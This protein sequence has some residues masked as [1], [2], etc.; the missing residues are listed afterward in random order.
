MEHRGVNQLV[1]PIKKKGQIK[2]MEK[3]SMFRGGGCSVEAVGHRCEG[4]N[5]GKHRYVSLP[6]Y[7]QTFHSDLRWF[8]PQLY[9]IWANVHVDAW[10]VFVLFA[11]VVQHNRRRITF[12]GGICPIPMAEF[13]LFVP[14]GNKS[15]H[16]WQLKQALHS[17]WFIHPPAGGVQE[18]L[19][20]SLGTVERC[21][22]DMY[23]H[24][25]TNAY[26]IYN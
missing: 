3:C 23:V 21:V 13:V 12:W 1:R 9:C 6:P 10:M 17:L 16:N 25:H 7:M 20:G 15:F 4:W 26:L 18:V 22:Q 24:M 5:W 19:T 14:L 2:R 11:N 8:F